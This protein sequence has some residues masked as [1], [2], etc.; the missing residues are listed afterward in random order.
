[1]S[2]ARGL[3]DLGNAY[4]DGA[5]SNRNLIINGAM[6]VAQR[7]TSFTGITFGSAKYTLDRYYADIVTS[8]SVAFTV[9]Q[10]SDAPQGFN[11]SLGVTLT[12]SGATGAGD[13]AFF[14]QIIE[15]YN[16][17]HLNFGTANAQTFTLSFWVK[18]SLTGTFGGYLG[19]A[20]NAR[21][22]T[23]SYTVSAANTWEYKTVTVSG[24]TEG[25]W[26]AINGVGLQVAWS[27]SCGTT[28]LGATGTWGDSLLL[29]ATGQTNLTETA[30]ATI[31]ITGVQLEVGDTATPF[32][33]RSD[34]LQRCQR[35]YQNTYEDVA[36]VGG[37]SSNG[38]IVAV[39]GYVSNDRYFVAMRFPTEMRAAPITVFY[40][41]RDDSSNTAARV[42]VY[43]GPTLRSFTASPAPSRKGLSGYFDTGYSDNAV[44]FQA[45]F[46]AEL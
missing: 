16:F 7:G 3:A 21:F 30:G 1:M 24:D 42:S 17:A 27:L 32:E 38:S 34:E 4:S 13:Y 5:L 2:K 36:D 41:G 28:Y 15:G 11:S 43:N 44:R 35:Y 22:R 39:T 29:G 23:F 20:A 9:A 31:N 10:S 19:A 26:N 12:A 6:Q 37:S 33:H 14:R 8:S 46:D 25:T 18:S 45:T 40:G